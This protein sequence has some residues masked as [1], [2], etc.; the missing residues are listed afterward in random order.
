MIFLRTLIEFSKSY[1]NEA[2]SLG[3][4]DFPFTTLAKRKWRRD[5][6]MK[7]GWPLGMDSGML[8][9]VEFS[10]M[11]KKGPMGESHRENGSWDV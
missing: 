7:K 3:S 2:K 8:H 1:T 6:E 10:R 4:S 5:P 11:P 9:N